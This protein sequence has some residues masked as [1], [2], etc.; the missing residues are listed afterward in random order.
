M[1][2]ERAAKEEAAKRAVAVEAA[3]RAAVA[4]RHRRI[5][6]AKEA[7]RRA[8]GATKEGTAKRATEGMADTAP[9]SWFVLPISLGTVVAGVAAA[10]FA[11]V[12]AAISFTDRAV[13]DGMYFLAVVL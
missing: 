4:I 10:L 7:I 5:A 1:A 2:A 6:I 8:Q 11:A 3:E 9:A 12:M 13:R